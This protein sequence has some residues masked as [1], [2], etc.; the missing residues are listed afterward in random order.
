MPAVILDMNSAPIYV[1]SSLNVGRMKPGRCYRMTAQVR[2]LLVMLARL[3]LI[4]LS[5]MSDP[6]EAWKHDDD[7]DDVHQLSCVHISVQTLFLAIT[8]N[9][10]WRQ[11]GHT[12]FQHPRQTSPI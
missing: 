12:S 7:D 1:G 6:C 3:L 4:H 9:L 5:S 10:S 2:Q 8:S 11:E